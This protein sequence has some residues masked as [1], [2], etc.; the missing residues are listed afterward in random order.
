MVNRVWNKV[1]SIS[2]LC[3]SCL[4][5]GV[6]HM[7]LWMAYLQNFIDSSIS[8]SSMFDAA[9]YFL[10][11]IVAFIATTRHHSLCLKSITASVLLFIIYVIWIKIN[12]LYK[13]SQST[14][15]RMWICLVIQS[16]I[17]VWT[18]YQ[19]FREYYQSNMI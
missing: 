5:R 13:L 16:E 18:S 12:T 15:I 14:F 4:K 9:D 17:E 3:T 6:K 7:P 1:Q 11:S 19:S 10:K 8:K 2:Q